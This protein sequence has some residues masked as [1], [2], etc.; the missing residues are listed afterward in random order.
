MGA[1]IHVI[2]TTLDGTREAL[3]AAIPLANGSR[4]ALVVLVPQIVPYAMEIDAPI[5]STACL[6]A[7]YEQIIEAFGGSA[8][9]EPCHCRTLNDI[10]AK[11]ELAGSTIVIGGPVGRWITSPEERFADRLT[12]LGYRVIFAAAGRNTTQRRVPLVAH[13][14]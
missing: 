14:A 6:V 3:R 8:R 4:A 9:I 7:R 1:T 13:H 2:A 5:A 11:I 12:R 10:G